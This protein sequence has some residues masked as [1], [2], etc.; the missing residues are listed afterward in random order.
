[1]KK[2]AWITFW[3]LAGWAA[4]TSAQTATPTPNFDANYDGIVDAMDLLLFQEYWQSGER[5][6]PTPVPDTP[7]PTATH[8]NRYRIV[9]LPGDVI[10]EFSMITSGSFEMGFPT[11][12]DPVWAVHPDWERPVHTVNIGYNFYM[13]KTEVTVAQWKAIMN[14]DPSQ[15]GYLGNQRPVERVSWNDS[16]V[17]I[18]AL[19]QLGQGTFR[20]PTEAEWEYS[21]RAGTDTLFHFGDSNCSATDSASCDL[22][23]YAWWPASLAS[24]PGAGTQ[25]VAQ[26]LPN[27][28]GLF[29]MY[30][31]VYEWCQ[32]DWHTNYYGAPSDGSSRGGGTSSDCVTRGAW[33]GYDEARKYTSSFRVGHPRIMRHDSIGLRLVREAD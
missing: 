25:P 20:L 1:M 23:N 16:Q 31:N 10:M 32:D 18:A 4:I 26:L 13:G 7:T 28:W 15:Y 3:L 2:R 22:G 9:T 19:N 27:A 29:D 5:Y 14:E 17:F 24:A 11:R 30:G 33:R 12:Y 8:D 21:C 6:T